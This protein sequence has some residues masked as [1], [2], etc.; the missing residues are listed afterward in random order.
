LAP[1]KGL[2]RRANHRHIFIIAESKKPRAGKSAAG[3]FVSE[4]LQ[5]KFLNRT[6]AAFSG[7]ANC[8]DSDFARG[9]S[10]R[11]AVRTCFYFAGTRERARHA[12]WTRSTLARGPDAPI[13]QADRAEDRFA[14]E[15]IA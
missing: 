7:A 9:V 4:S 12:A 14:P 13:R 6:A 2:T 8:H 10:E 3:F 11:A 1:K 15:M 5:S